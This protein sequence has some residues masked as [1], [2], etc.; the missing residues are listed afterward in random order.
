[1][2]REAQIKTEI[3]FSLSTRFISPMCI[4]IDVI[5]D[6]FHAANVLDFEVFRR[7]IININSVVNVLLNQVVK[8]RMQKTVAGPSKRVII[9]VGP[10]S[11][12]FYDRISLSLSLVAV[13]F[14]A[15][16]E[17]GAKKRVRAFVESIRVAR[18]RPA[19]LD[20]KVDVL[21]GENV[22]GRPRRS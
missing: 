9:S 22:Y 16:P 14:D 15:I 7:K 17:R 2:R 1:M 8:L 5:T 11:H 4:F 10:R 18:Q 13:I 3:G 19:R 6:R 12:Y 21:E 20:R